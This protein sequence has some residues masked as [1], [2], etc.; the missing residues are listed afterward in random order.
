[1][2]QQNKKIIQQQIQKNL[3]QDH[4]AYFPS[5]KEIYHVQSGINEWPYPKTFRG[6]P[7]T[8]IPHVWERQAGYQHIVSP[9]LTSFTPKPFFMDTCFQPACNTLFPCRKDQT[10]LPLQDH[11][12]FHSP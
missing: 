9:P 6:S 11:C 1:M 5:S 8:A 4:Q 2:N 3:Q 10:F 7:S 12:V